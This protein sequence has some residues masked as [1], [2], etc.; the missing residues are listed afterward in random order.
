MQEN[1]PD[2]SLSDGEKKASKYKRSKNG[3]IKNRLHFI[4]RC[5]RKEGLSINDR[6]WAQ[7]EKGID[8]SL[9]W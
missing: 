7:L 1:A 2:I 6:I 8:T 3:N 5:V 4:E 9:K